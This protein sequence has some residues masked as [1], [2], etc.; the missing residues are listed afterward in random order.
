MQVA[1][2]VCLGYAIQQHCHIVGQDSSDMSELE[3]ASDS[4]S[5]ACTSSAWSESESDDAPCLPEQDQPCKAQQATM[6]KHTSI[7][8]VSFGRCTAFSKQL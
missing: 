2:H 6:S 4:D 1:L 3:V 5:D 7:T 8:D